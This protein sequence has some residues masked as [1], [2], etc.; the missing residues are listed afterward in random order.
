ML[1]KPLAE[2]NKH[3]LD[4]LISGQVPEGKTLEYK[5]ELPGPGIRINQI[6]LIEVE[7][8]RKYIAAHIC[9]K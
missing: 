9:H 6:E 3:D 7:L 4:A 8:A 1:T 2:L 5:R